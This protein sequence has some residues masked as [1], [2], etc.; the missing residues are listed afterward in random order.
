MIAMYKCLWPS[1]S[2]VLLM[3]ASAL[4]VI[5]LLSGW[6]AG[7]QLPDTESYLAALGWPDSLGA[8]RHPLYGILLLPFGRPP[9]F[10]A[11]AAVHT[12]IHV[13]ACFVLFA[14]ACVARLPAKAAFSLAV[15]AMLAQGFLIW[16]RFAIPESPAVSLLI[17]TVGLT[18]AASRSHRSYKLLLIPIMLS[19]G[20]AYT[21]RP[22]I[23]PA[24]IALPTLWAVLADRRKTTRIFQKVT[25][26]AL[27]CAT[28]YLL[29]AAVRKLVVNDFNISSFGGY[30]ASGLAGLI[31]DDNIIARLPHDVQPTASAVLET[32][33][34]GELAGDVMPTPRN[35]SGAQSVNSISLGYF[36]FWARNYDYLLPRIGALRGP[37]ESWVEF[38]KRMMRFSL[39]VVIAAPDRWASWIAG[40][41]ARLVGRMIVFNVTFCVA[42]I[43][44]L[45]VFIFR[46]LF[47]VAPIVPIPG[48]L[49][50]SLVVVAWIF[51]TAPLSVLMTFPGGR[52][53]D[54][55]SALL[56]AIPLF[57]ALELWPKRR[58]QML[59][60]ETSPI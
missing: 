24:I 44:M 28:P 22:T 8:I 21:L 52:Y 59:L 56:A 48:F 31:L 41:S 7:G 18:L 47:G 42:T 27:V 5:L 40:A 49:E 6:L 26:F 51:A 3:L 19:I 32:R 15:S 11:I 14:G 39:G 38:D 25:V 33:R 10:A 36:D 30:Q 55:V 16:G 50:L 2:V 13:G 23:L 17:L 43:L 53:I 54:T 34:A 57:V 12:V 35:S 60:R 37:T 1:W 46:R 45:L 20:L 4:T 29:Q 58:R 9:S